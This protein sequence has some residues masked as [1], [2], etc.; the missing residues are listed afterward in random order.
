[1]AYDEQKLARTCGVS[2]AKI[3][4]IAKQGIFTTA[5]DDA[6]AL[7]L[8]TRY[9][10]ATR[11]SAEA[12]AR[13]AKAKAEL[14]ETKA[15]AAKRKLDRAAP[16]IEAIPGRRKNRGGKYTPALAARLLERLC[17]G[18]SLYRA[19]IAEGVTEN[20]VREWVKYYPEF[21]ARYAQARKDGYVAWGDKFV[22]LL[23]DSIVLSDDPALDPQEKSVRLS[24][25]KLVLDN[26]KWLLCKMLPKVY[27]DSSTVVHTTA[28]EGGI[29][30]AHTGEKLDA[31]IER[32]A[33]R[34]AKYAQME[35]EKHDAE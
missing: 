8:V 23:E 31:V 19:S 5:T 20:A 30:L 3:R 13:S 25:I 1:M 35:V 21:S 22:K 9:L 28:S 11:D 33:A 26:L 24:A 7:V 6:S 4:E 12:K 10:F 17:N 16:L 32:V 2:V 18:E 14:E 27:G 29:T 34:Q 15:A